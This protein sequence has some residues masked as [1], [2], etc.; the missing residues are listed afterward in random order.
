MEKSYVDDPLEI[1]LPHLDEILDP[2]LVNVH[3][4]F[5]P[6]LGQTSGRSTYPPVNLNHPELQLVV[7]NGKAFTELTLKVTVKVAA[8]VTAKVT[9]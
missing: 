5:Y 1:W 7:T 9:A 4:C 6:V 2:P 3:I 8:K